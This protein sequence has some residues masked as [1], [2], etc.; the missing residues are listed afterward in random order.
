MRAKQFGRAA[1]AALAIT[2]FAAACGD[3]DD[4]DDAPT[5]SP[6]DVTGGGITEPMVETTTAT[7]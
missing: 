2:A 6:A 4:D 1:V 7:S 3:D 5:E